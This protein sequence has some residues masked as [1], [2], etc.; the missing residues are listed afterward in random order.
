MS[1][2]VWCDGCVMCCLC[3]LLVVGVFCLSYVSRKDQELYE[4]YLIYQEF[5]YRSCTH[6]IIWCIGVLCMCVYIYIY[7][8]I[9]I[10]IYILTYVTC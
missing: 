7:M 10:Y 4:E 5:V 8:Y 2:I 9:Y 3:C 6:C 1:I